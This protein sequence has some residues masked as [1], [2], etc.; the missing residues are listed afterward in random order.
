ML[1][2]SEAWVVPAKDFK[3]PNYNVFSADR[4]DDRFSGGVETFCNRII[5]HISTPTPA[6]RRL[7][8]SSIVVNLA[9]SP[10]K[11]VSAY[12]SLNCSMW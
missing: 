5:D 1:L 2:V 8:A 7:N 3:L 4:E 6:F 9:K 11:I 10:I 12:Q